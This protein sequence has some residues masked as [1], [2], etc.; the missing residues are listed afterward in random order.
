[1]ASFVNVSDSEIGKRLV[2]GNGKCFIRGT[3]I[4]QVMGRPRSIGQRRLGCAYI[5]PPIDLA[6]VGAD[7]FAVKLLAQRQAELGL[8]HGCRTKENDE[9]RID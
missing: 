5:H 2:L 4:D 8:A 7:N 1:M 3:D 9:G 6:A